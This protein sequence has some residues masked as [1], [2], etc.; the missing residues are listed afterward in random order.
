MPNLLVTQNPQLDA[1]ISDRDNRRLM[2]LSG[3]SMATPVVAGAAALMLQV[4]PKLTP[5]M[6]KLILMYTAQPLAGFN[7]LEQGAGEVN[8]EGAVRLAKLVRTDLTNQTASGAPMLTASAPDPHT[9]I[10][11][12]TF[13][14]AQGILLKQRYATG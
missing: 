6:C 10:A 3:T 1:G 8:I 12:Q 2:Y 13:A 14:W 5:N 9:T 4:N 11:G 7:T